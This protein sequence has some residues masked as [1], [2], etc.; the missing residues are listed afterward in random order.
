MFPKRSSLVCVYERDCVMVSVMNLVLVDS[1]LSV[2]FLSVYSHSDYSFCS[3][4]SL[5]LFWHSLLSLYPPSLSPSCFQTIL[6]KLRDN[7]EDFAWGRRYFLQSFRPQATDE[8]LLMMAVYLNVVKGFVPQAWLPMY[9]AGAAGGQPPQRCRYEM[10]ISAVHTG[11]VPVSV[12]CSVKVLM[13]FL[14]GHI[15]SGDQKTT[16]R[17][18]LKVLVPKCMLH[19]LGLVKY[20]NVQMNLSKKQKKLCINDQGFTMVRLTR[21][22]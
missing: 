10:P 5:Y 6:Q 13:E 11:V 19:R 14:K 17:G 18:A 9:D 15:L 22:P 1:S 4:Y 7:Q 16:L 20:P 3:L 12:R 21:C 8:E 2:L